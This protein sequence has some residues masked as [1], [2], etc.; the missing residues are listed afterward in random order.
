MVCADGV[1][2]S[3]SVLEIM[4]FLLMNMRSGRLLRGVIWMNV[5][6]KD[7]VSTWSGEEQVIDSA[8]FTYTGAMSLS[9]WLFVNWVK[10]LAKVDFLNK[11]NQKLCQ[12][13]RT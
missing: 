13:L 10:F 6:L 12:A 1:A 5:I 2:V 11:F 3:K 4:D 9:C 7:S 8:Q